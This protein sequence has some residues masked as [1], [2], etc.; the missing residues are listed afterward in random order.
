MPV[1]S[2]AKLW[3]RIY[4]TGFAV[5]SAMLL[6]TLFTTVPYGDLSRLGR[7]SDAAF[8][9]QQ[10]PPRLPDT[11]QLRA[12]PL[13]QADIVVIGDSF[14]MTYVWQS[15]LVRAGYR[16]TTIYW[17][18]YD[19]TMCSDVQQWLIDAGFRGKLVIFES[20]ERLLKERLKR[21]T[22][23]A[24]MTKAFASRTTPPLTALAE[25]PGFAI[26]STATLPTGVLTWYRTRSARKATGDVEFEQTQVRLVP[27]GCALFSNPLCPKV[28][29]FK[30]DVDAGELD[31]SDF[32]RMKQF[33]ARQVLI[34]Y[35]WLV[36]PDKTTTYLDPGHSKSFRDV[37]LPAGLGPDF[38][39]MTS[40]NRYRFKDL[41]FPNDT[42]MSMYGQAIL[43]KLALEA[44]RS[45]LAKPAVV[46]Q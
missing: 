27:D 35:I 36:L 41:Y 32:E 9:W 22:Q 4:L 44:V 1:M 45:A 12:V 3:L 14:S 13:N 28:L 31:A 5:V 34:P 26:N 40:E 10:P 25:K 23:C 37:F 7:L 21:S 17:G 20:V 2:P 30:Q 39:A 46:P 38:F 8:G 24:R 15:E 16:V 18:S 43:G 6:V 42:H 29:F 19:E 33:N 11:E